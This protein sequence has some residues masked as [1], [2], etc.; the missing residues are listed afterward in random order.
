MLDLDPAVEHAQVGCDA[1]RWQGETTL[2]A[3]ARKEEQRRQQ[4]ET[5]LNRVLSAFTKQALVSGK[6]QR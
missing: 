3:H 6:F 4:P 1:V 2:R 5:R